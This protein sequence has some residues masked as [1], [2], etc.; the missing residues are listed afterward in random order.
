[1]SFLP[2]HQQPIPSWQDFERKTSLALESKLRSGAL[3][4]DLPASLSFGLTGS[5][6]AVEA[7]A[8]RATGAVGAS[9]SKRITA[10]KL[11][12]WLGLAIIYVH[13]AWIMATSVLIIAYRWVDPSV[14][15][16]MAYRK[17]GYGWKLEEPRGIALKKVPAYLRSMLV[18]VEDDTF[19]E[20]HGISMAAFKRAH[21]INERL[22]KPLYGGSTLT[23]Q[24]SRTL[25]L[26]PVK[27]YVRKYFEVIAA[28]ELELFLPKQR[29]LELYFGYAEWG[30]GVFGIEAASRQYYGSPVSKLSRE[31]GARLIAL[32]SSPI[33][34]SPST[35]QKSLILRERYGYL[36]R[37]YVNG[38]ATGASPGEASAAASAPKPPATPEPGQEAVADTNAASSA[39]AGTAPVSNEA[40]P[41]QPSST[42]NNTAPAN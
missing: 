29:I 16:L 41:S 1:M 36:V 24:V 34:Y 26:V 4:V 6:G 18:A 13:L 8:V 3:S 35:L 38:G 19:Y 21:E 14:T 15:V 2:R 33:K 10:R 17:W 28:L 42:Q 37:R 20:H 32:L 23:M 22:G 31:Q 9:D 11:L 27:S 39:A 12:R 30:K 25:F 40:V 7:V 5:Q